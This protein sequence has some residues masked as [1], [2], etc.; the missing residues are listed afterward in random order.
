MTEMGLGGG[1]F[2]TAQYGYHLREADLYF[3]I[4]DPIA[5]C[6]LPDGEEGEVV[7]TTLTRQAMPLIRYRTGDISRFL[8]EKCPC[9]TNLKTLEKIKRRVD[10]RIAISSEVFSIGDFDEVLFRQD[11]I[12]N[13]K[14]EISRAGNKEQLGFVIYSI[15]ERDDQTEIFQQAVRNMN[16]SFSDIE[17]KLEMAYGYPTEL[18]SMKKRQIIDD[19]P[20]VFKK[21]V[22]N[23]S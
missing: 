11:G 14:M 7:F 16:K 2:C 3:E 18:G 8:V 15:Y 23:Y 19:F 22:A 5:G 4:I 21:I 9:G 1:V 13:Y 10:Q 6:V 12:L 20:E 17:I